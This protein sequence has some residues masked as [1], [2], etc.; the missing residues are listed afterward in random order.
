MTDFRT[1]ARK[2]QNEP[3]GSCTRKQEKS[4]E[5]FVKGYVKKDINLKGL[6]L[7]KSGTMWT[8]KYITVVIDYNQLNKVGSMSPYRYKFNE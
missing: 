6:S 2:V 7:A 8:S 1:G 5:Y 4:Q 3:G